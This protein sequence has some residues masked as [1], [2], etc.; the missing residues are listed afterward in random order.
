RV[1]NKHADSKHHAEDDRQDVKS[2]KYHNRLR[3]V[4]AHERTLV[5]EVENQPRNPAKQVTQTA[6]HVFF[7]SG[8]PRRHRCGGRACR[9][10]ARYRRTAAW[11]ECCA[12]RCG[13]STLCTKSHRL[14]P[15]VVG[16]VLLLRRRVAKGKSS[17]KRIRFERRAA[18]RSGGA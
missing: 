3:R 8:P 18:G 5:C 14:S 6:C 10:R 11:A 1:G 13:R 17:G 7:H 12:V 15:G 4:K 2:A 9:C 16:W